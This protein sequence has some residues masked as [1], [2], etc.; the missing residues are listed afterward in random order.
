MFHPELLKNKKILVTGGGTGL[1]KEIAGHYLE[2]GAEVAICG[3]R[4]PVLR[5][6]AEG[7]MAQ[8]GGTVTVHSVDI[9]DHQAVDA[10][11]DTIWQQGPL[12]G[13]VNNAAGNFLSRTEDLSVN[14]FNAITNIVLHG[15][16]YVTQ[17]VGRRWLEAGLP[18]SIIN[19]LVTWIWTG[20]PFTVPSAMSKAGLAAMTKSLAVEWGNRGIRINGIAPGPFP[21]EGASKRLNLSTIR[22]QDSQDPAEQT[23]AVRV[24]LGRIG[25]MRELTNLATFLMADGCDYLTGEIIAIDGGQWLAGHGHSGHLASLGDAEWQAI[26]EAIQQTNAADKKLRTS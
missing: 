22:G 2:L 16:F 9:R 15:T 1:G 6:T 5:E 13:L 11:I 19:I 8:H 4:E 23:P 20:G 26:R 14:G 12:T 10:M 21:T 24:P 17:S 18:G 7:L 25:Q 3:R